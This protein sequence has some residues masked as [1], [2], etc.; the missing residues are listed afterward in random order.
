MTVLEPRRETTVLE[1]REEIANSVTHGLGFLL[2]L[3]GIVPL[4]VFALRLDSTW[5]VVSCGIYG[6]TLVYLYSAST[7]YHGIQRRRL[8][9]VLRILDHT[10]IY[11]LIAGTYTPFAL[12]PL[13]SPWEWTMLG[14]VWSL[15]VVGIIAKIAYLHRDRDG[16]STTLYLAIGWLAGIGA[17]M[18]SPGTQYWIVLGGLLYMLGLVFFLQTGKRFY[19]TIWH[20]FVLAGSACHYFAVILSILPH[21]D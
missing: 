14:T 17:V 16:L 7:L 20:L 15:V 12:V 19:H 11:L 3:V 13:C 8:K 1:H 21:S 10:A 18:R 4:L 6:V 5:R 2:S 9:E